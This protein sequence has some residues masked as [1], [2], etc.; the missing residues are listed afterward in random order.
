MGIFQHLQYCRHCEADSRKQGPRHSNPL[1]RGMT[2]LSETLLLSGPQE[3]QSL[4]RPIA[5][6]GCRESGATVAADRATARMLPSDPCARLNWPVMFA[7]QP[8]FGLGNFKATGTAFPSI[9]GP[10]AP[11]QD[12]K[13][14]LLAQPLPRWWHL[15]LDSIASGASCRA[16]TCTPTARTNRPAV[17]FAPRWLAAASPD[18]PLSFLRRHCDANNP[19]RCLPIKAYRSDSEGIILPSPLT[20]VSEM[21]IFRKPC[22]EP[23]DSHG[24]WSHHSYLG[25]G[26]PYP[27]PIRTRP[28]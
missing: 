4:S 9:A 11:P 8:I 19:A 16:V 21:G 27:E 5:R 12:R 26:M 10:P 1:R 23:L 14:M 15:S 25:V 2:T 24:I 22:V 17:D 13:L 18:P 3:T 28:S 20:T 6:S 7:T